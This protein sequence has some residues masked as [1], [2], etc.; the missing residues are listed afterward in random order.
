MTSPR[1]SQDE[2]QH[3]ALIYRLGLSHEEIER[4]RNQ[5]SDILENFQVL[6]EVDTTDVPPTGHS[7]ALENVMRQDEATSPLS[8]EDIL[9]N[10]PR[11]EGDYFRVKAVLD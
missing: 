2:V 4:L 6:D 8:K 5:L 9:A 7:V 3:I 10:A 1:L 11:R